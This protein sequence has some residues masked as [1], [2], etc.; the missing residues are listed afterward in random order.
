MRNAYSEIMQ[1]YAHKHRIL[2]SSQ[3]VRDFKQVNSDLS[4]TRQKLDT[5]LSIERTVTVQMF[6][7]AN[8]DFA[9][10]HSFVSKTFSQKMEEVKTAEIN[11]REAEAQLAKAKKTYIDA[12]VVNKK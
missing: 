5:S 12:R 7:I 6:S 1:D 11:L 3:F 9:K 8:Q 10:D 4:Q 2:K